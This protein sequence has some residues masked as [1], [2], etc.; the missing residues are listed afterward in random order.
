MMTVLIMF[1]FILCDSDVNNSFTVKCL[2]LVFRIR[3]GH[4][5]T[6]I[7]FIQKYPLHTSK[8]SLEEIKLDRYRYLKMMQTYTFAVHQDVCAEEVMISTGTMNN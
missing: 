6:R 4:T 2:K 7:I 5:S 1:M 8:S 3:K